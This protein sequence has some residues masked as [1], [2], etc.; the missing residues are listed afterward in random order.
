MS[1]HYLIAVAFLFLAT[2]APAQHLPG[3]SSV[4][5]VTQNGVPV[6]GG[7]NDLELNPASFACS[8]TGQGIACSAY[9]STYITATPGVDCTGTTDSS[10]GVQNAV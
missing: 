7:E 2:R 5:A 1:R 10:T 9:T 8:C 6:C 3:E 4:A